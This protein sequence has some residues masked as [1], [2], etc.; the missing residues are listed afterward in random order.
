MSV[1]QICQSRRWKW[2][3]GPARRL[4][5]AGDAVVDV[6]AATGQDEV[7]RS[8][9]IYGK[10]S[11]GFFA[12]RQAIGAEAFEAALRDLTSRYV[13]R[14]LNHL[15]KHRLTEARPRRDPS[16]GEAP[17]L[18][19]SSGYVQRSIKDFPR[20]GTVMPWKLYQNYALDLLMLK[21]SRLADGVLQ[22]A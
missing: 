12:I 19:F 6:P 2:T 15:D 9:A 8:A 10:G 13:C 17:L 22:F 18:D 21:R 20:Q 11:L 7:T 14:L 4:L 5:S 3:T 16:I 1:S